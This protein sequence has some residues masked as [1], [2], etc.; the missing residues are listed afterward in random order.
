MLDIRRIRENL[1]DIKKAMDRRGEKEF[2]LDI[3]VELDD[4]RRELLKEVEVMKNEMNVESKKI[5]QLIKEGKDVT[6]DKARLKELSDKIKELDEKVRTVSN[7]I[8]YNLMRIPNVPNPEV[9]QGTTDEDNVEIR[10]WGEPTKFNFEEKAH[11]DIGTK[12]GILDF[13]TAGKITGSRFTLYKGLGARLER[14]LI[15]FFLNTHTEEHGYTEVLPPFMANRASFIGT[16]QLPKFEEDMFAVKGTNYYLIPTAEVPVTNLHRGDVLSADQ[17]P[18]KYC[19]YTACFRAEAGSAGRDTRG[20][21]RQ[22]QFNKVELVKFAHPDHSF[23]ELESLRKDAEGILQK[24]NL[25]YRVLSICTKDIGFPHAKQ[26]D[27]EVWAAGQQRWLEVSSCSCFTDF[28]ARRAGIRFK[29]ADGGKARFV[30]TLNGSG[31]AIPR[32]LAAILENNIRDDGKVEVPEVL[33]KWY[34]KE[35][36]GA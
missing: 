36:L 31:L 9:P 17:L 15:N 25:P 34:G 4:K 29:P 28:Q 16:G 33:R 19:A 5:P 26:Y 12:L 8:E 14:A 27:L 3:V 2:N 18:I 10:T 23:E 35:T 32:V 22:H 11:W 7:E 13:E 1:D 24:L 20:L 21:I 6:E 30:H